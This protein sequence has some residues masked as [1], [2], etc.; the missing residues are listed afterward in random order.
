M[1]SV[2]RTDAG[3]YHFTTAKGLHYTITLIDYTEEYQLGDSDMA[4]GRIFFFILACKNPELK[5]GIDSRVGKTIE[6]FINDFLTR[7]TYAIIYYAAFDDGRQVKRESRFKRWWDQSVMKKDI[8]KYYF[9][10]RGQT[11]TLLVHR[12]NSFKDYILSIFE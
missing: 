2:S 11:I 8:E 1:Y 12:D 10:M 3:T 6:A 7:N 5:T 9:D 4:D